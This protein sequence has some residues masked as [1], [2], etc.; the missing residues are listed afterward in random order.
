MAKASIIV[1]IYN[2]EKYLDRSIGSLI[3]QTF[4]DLEIIAIN[5]NSTD[6]SYEILHRI[7]EKN[8]KKMII[9][10][11][12][13]N[14]GPAYSRNIGL[15]AA[16]GD[17][18][19]FIDADD[20]VNLNMYEDLIISI[21]ESNSDIAR[22]NR[23]IKWGGFNVSFIGRSANTNKR[24]IIN[25]KDDL[26]YLHKEYPCVTNK[27]LRRDLIGDRKF[28]ENIKWEDYPFIIPIMYNANKVITVPTSTYYYHVNL[29]G[30]TIT[31]SKKLT[32]KLLDIITANQLIEKELLRESNN[33]ELKEEI[34]FIAIQNILSRLRDILL[35]K[36]S[37][38]E[39]KELLTLFLQYID[40]VYG[41]HLANNKYKDYINSRFLL[42]LRMNIIELLKDKKYISNNP[43]EEIQKILKK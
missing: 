32:P 18:I 35:S 7:K 22:S 28:P 31:D 21:E 39:K 10:N 5:D 25:P 13:T 19:G 3:N 41:D 27:L 33:E 15:D 26:S 30:T 38:K 43:I 29:K 9:L 20:S 23:I 37:I 6:N 4:K 42:S 16:T 1:P 11:N 40:E 17:L 14:K 8:P 36:I 2:C 34:N 12:D 24:V